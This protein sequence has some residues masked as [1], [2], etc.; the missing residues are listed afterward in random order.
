MLLTADLSILSFI[1]LTIILINAYNRSE[2]A[3]LQNKMFMALIVINMFMLVLDWMAWT[4]NGLPGEL[5]FYLNFGFNFLLYICAPAAPIMWAIYVHYQVFRD[6][7]RLKAASFVFIV[8][9]VVNAALIILNSFTGWVFSID[10]ANIYHRGDYFY[11]HVV[12]CYAIITYSLCILLINRKKL[13]KRYLIALLLFFIPPSIGILVQA[14]FYGMSY[15]WIGMM[16]SILIIYINIQNRGLNTDHLTGIYNKRQFESHAKEKM[17]NSHS[18]SAISLDLDAFKQINDT[19]GHDVG[20]EALKDAAAIIKKSI[21]R[22]DFVA[23][24]GGDEFVVLLD[25][26]NAVLLE[27]TVN[28]IRANADI[29]NKTHNK[30]FSISFSMGYDT[31]D[32]SSKMGIDAFFS[33]V[34]KLMYEEKRKKQ[35]NV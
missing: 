12:Y 8:I 15:N 29:F 28:R 22:N 23:R 14:L 20:D 2:K 13:E 3:L 35:Q 5:H 21:R 32:P 11:L 9:F 16:L 25:L 26:F 30:S 6:E 7:R 4:F 33:H 19:Y 1:I 27:E 34:D 10:H 17:R 18:F 31:Y 24:V